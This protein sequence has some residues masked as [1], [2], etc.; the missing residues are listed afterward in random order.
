MAAPYAYTPAIW[1]PLAGA[2]FA[3]GMVWYS[4][5]RR[6]VPA[7][8]PL[9]CVFAISAV[10]FLASALSAAAVAPEAAVAWFKVSQACLVPGITAGTCFVLEYVYPG[11]W[12]TPRNLADSDVVDALLVQHA[13]VGV[14][15]ALALGCRRVLEV[16]PLARQLVEF[17]LNDGRQV[18]LLGDDALAVVDQ[19]LQLVLVRPDLGLE[20]LH[21]PQS[22][23]NELEE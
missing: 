20:R 4:W 12:L 16:L 19:L 22:S 18:W 10:C 17:R 15:Q 9:L 13:A 8:W 6:T 7:V 14:E 23:L 3:L 21:T 1:L 2:L 11:R 5:R